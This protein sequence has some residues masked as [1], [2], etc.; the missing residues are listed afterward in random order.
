MAKRIFQRMSDGTVRP[1]MA[2]KEI[3]YNESPA[4]TITVEKKKFKAGQD[5][6]YVYINNKPLES[7]NFPVYD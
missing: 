5:A 3:V 1:K 2:D 7:F 6:Y 4:I